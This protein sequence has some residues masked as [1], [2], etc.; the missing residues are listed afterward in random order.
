MIEL[1]VPIMF[2]RYVDIEFGTGALKV[3]PAHDLNDNEIGERHKLETIDIFNADGTMS[4]EAHFYVGKDRFEVRKLIAKDLKTAGHVVKIEDYRNNV[5]RSERTNAVI[6]PRLTLQWFLKMGDFAKTALDAVEKEEVRFYPEHMWNMYHNWLNEDNIKDWCISRQLWW[7]QRIPA[8]YYEDHIFVAANEEEALAQAKEKT[9]N[10]ALTIA[11][12]KQDEDVVDTWFSSW[13]WPISV[14]D[15]FENQEELKY[16]YPTN[17][18][19]T[20]WDIMFF[21]VARMIMAGYE[22]SGDL[23]GPEVA[24]EKGIHP[25][26]DVYFTGMV[27]DNQRR[28]MSKSL[29]NS[30]DALTLIEN[31]GADGVRF[32]MLSSGAAGN[33]IIFDAKID[34]KTKEVENQSAKCDQGL[35]FCN[36][37]WQGLNFLKKLEIVEEPLDEANANI[38][39]LAGAWLDNKLQ[40]TLELIENNYKEYRLSDALMNLYNFIWN[41]FFSEYIEMIKPAYQKPID[42]AT[43]DQAIGFFETLMTA[44]HPFLPFVTEE[45]WH[46]LRDRKP[47]EDCIVSTYPKARTYDAALIKTVDTAIDVISKVRFNRNDK[48]LKQKDPLSLYVKDSASAKKLYAMDGMIPI[49]IKRAF[50]SELVFTEETEISNTISFVSGTEE[51]LMEINKEIDKEAERERMKKELI[52]QEGFLVGVGKKLSNERFV[53]NA[54]EAVVAKERKKMEDAQARIKILKE[55]LDKLD[56]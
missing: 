10:T 12:L 35:K 11:D 2:D 29:G 54:P 43:Y 28:K 17:T 24:K 13:L 1:S 22:W 6:E 5:G 33:D 37:M 31:Y 14:F 18:L 51:Y 50:L 41:D 25:F 52:Q 21:W 38:N 19:V 39:R 46:Q 3:T 47:G 8:W 34:P 7:G 15:G 45:I 9:G 40:Q 53:S 55:S 42:R 44:L 36:K 20:G 27:R 32:G 16:Y 23:L 49:V 56:N 30:P 4:K 26:K 48:G